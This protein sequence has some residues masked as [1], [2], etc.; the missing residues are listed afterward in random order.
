MLGT[1]GVGKKRL[2]PSCKLPV[3]V[4]DQRSNPVILV[5]IGKVEPLKP[6]SETNSRL[7]A[8]CLTKRL[9]VQLFCGA[10]TLNSVWQVI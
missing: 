6:D 4:G 8:Y 1:G 5:H 7:D 2:H 3:G 9:F 10:V